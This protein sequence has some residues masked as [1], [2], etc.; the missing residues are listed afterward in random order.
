MSAELRSTRVQAALGRVA[1]DPGLRD[2]FA[3]APEATLAELGLSAEDR[4]GMLR[5]GPTRLLAYHE[6][7]HSRLLST[8]RS[9]LGG[10]AQRL[11]PARLRADL[12]AWVAGPGPTSAYLRDVPAEF[13]AWV[14][15]RWAADES[16]PPWLVELADHQVLI[17]TVRNDPREIGEPTGLGLE[18]ERPIAVNP[19]VRLVRYRWAVHRL[20]KRFGPELEPP[21][22]PTIVIA[23]RDRDEQPAFVEIKPRS[24]AMLERL[25][26]GE[27]LREALFGACAAMGETL[28][29][30][31]LGVTAVTLADLLDRGVLLGAAPTPAGG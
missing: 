1:R 19:T 8:I 18:L 14:R 4:A 10:A 2:R 15:P 27:T 31:I 9:F 29:D 24:A 21:A 3:A 22:E 5:Y 20:P 17:R 13:L 12:D 16:L 26:A 25:I 28:D 11:G 7:V 6:M 30:R 23:H